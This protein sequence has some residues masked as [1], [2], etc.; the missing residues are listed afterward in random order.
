MAATETSLTLNAK[1]RDNAS[2]PLSDI[3]KSVKALP[4]QFGKASAALG[5][6]GGV[7]QQMGGQVAAAAQK[8]TGLASVVAS[9]GPIGVGIAAISVAVAAG[10]KVWEVY[11]ESSRQAEA[12]ARALD[13]VFAAQ[14]K[15]IDDSKRRVEELSRSLRNFGKTTTEA[16]Q[17]DLERKIAMQTQGLEG[18]NA[19]I[20]KQEARNKEL[21]E[22][23]TRVVQMYNYRTQ[24]VVELTAE[25]EE[26]KRL[27][28]LVINGLK[29][30]AVNLQRQLEMDKQAVQLA[31]E[32][33][34]KETQA[35]QSKKRKADATRNAAKEQQDEN[36]A[37]REA[38]AAEE[39][40]ARKVGE[41]LAANFNMA[42]AAYA[43]EAELSE[44]N[45]KYLQE[46]EEKATKDA[47]DENNKRIQMTQRYAD[48]LVNSVGGAFADIIDGSKSA[49]Q[50]F[51]DM[52]KSLG[53]M[54]LQQASTYLVAKGIEMAANKT[55]ADAK[56]AEDTSTAAS[57]A[58]SAHSNI[59]FVGIAIGLAAAAAI[60]GAIFAFKKF[61]TGGV[62]KGGIPGVDSIP[63]FLQDNERVLTPRQNNNFE[64]FIGMIGQLLGGGQALAVP[65]IAGG[66]SS[67]STSLAVH[68]HSSNWGMPERAARQKFVRSDMDREVREAIR[69]GYFRELVRK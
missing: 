4:D 17:A 55:A 63:A 46:Q 56:I 47:E 22:S 26:E 27:N 5:A 7:T 16:T 19:E 60:I 3:A 30:S 8:L 35:E 61:A 64:T 53:K 25:Q 68:L 38:A 39:A 18:L 66:P 57:G 24:A 1:A 10:T 41:R 14:A 28:E 65:A 29:T 36:K 58:L 15:G 48:V 50:A 44:K 54:V 9:G 67:S 62:A 40:Y 11:T 45:A 69:D 6:L 20:A 33:A 13:G 37:L 12:A 43:R 31:G 2:G 21:V 34:Q 59:P 23:N 32:L 42:S 52:F 49:D 51:G